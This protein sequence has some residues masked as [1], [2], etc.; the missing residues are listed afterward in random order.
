VEEIVI[1]KFPIDTERLAELQQLQRDNE[2]LQDRNS[3]MVLQCHLAAK[4]LKQVAD[5]LDRSAKS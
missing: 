4:V 3:A 5:A 1:L 2:T